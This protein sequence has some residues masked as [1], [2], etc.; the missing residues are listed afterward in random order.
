MKRVHS[1]MRKLRLHTLN[2][3]DGRTHAAARARAVARELINALGGPAVI[4]PVQRQ[5]CERAG[6]YTAIAEDL[7][8]RKL[9]G[10]SVCGDD[11]FRAEGVARRAV[12]AVMAMR[13]EKSPPPPFSP[14]KAMREAA[15]AKATQV[16]PSDDQPAS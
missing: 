6:I 14:M 7:A 4:T 9:A 8:S 5:A 10:L 13:P 16:E 12:A 15:R 2:D 1:R 11:L 3:I